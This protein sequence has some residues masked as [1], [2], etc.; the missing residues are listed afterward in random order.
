MHTVS[1][2]SE[3]TLSAETLE[4]NELIAL[5]ECPFPLP[6][7]E[8][9]A[10]LL[11]QEAAQYGHK[12][13]SFDPVRGRLSGYRDRH[14]ADRRRLKQL[15]RG[16]SESLTGWLA[17]A[18]P[19]YAAGLTRDRVTIRTQEEATRA[20]RLTARNDL[21]HI[22]N[23][24]TRPTM[25][26]RILRVYVN[27]NPN[28]PHVWATSERFPELL[29]RFVAVHRLP[30]RSVEEW[31]SPSQSVLRLFTG[32][33]TGRSLY[34]AFMLRLHH[35]LKESEPFQAQAPRKVCS[36]A[37]QSAWM[38]FSDGLAHAQL[39]GRF[40]L[41]HSYFVPPDCLV[42]PADWPVTILTMVHG[43]PACR[44]G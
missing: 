23:F 21:L 41:E 38:L 10:F 5:P 29:A 16:F 33:K 37:P 25:G 8:D 17:T 28:E 7:P 11:G 1:A 12:D 26:R 35:F 19:H 22:D 30:A 36:F 9:V 20:L 4:R 2:I 42:Q 34:D 39:R 44:V 43:E 40:A 13:I 32:R 27:I 14:N 15:L 3:L 6:R 18:L 24:A 31:L